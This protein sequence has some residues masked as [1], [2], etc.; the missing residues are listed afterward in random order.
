[1][2]IFHDVDGCLNTPDGSPIGFSKT[3]LSEN[4]IKA[5]SDL[6]QLIDDSAVKHFVLNTGRN[7]DAT[8][9]L[10]PANSVNA[11]KNLC[12]EKGHLS[13]Y[14]YIATTSE[15]IETER[16][17]ITAVHFHFLHG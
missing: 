11:V 2:I 14:D 7:W 3:A 13:Q 1:M 9:Y 5:L 8:E 17:Y 4:L 6:G 12:R 16:P 15:W 10:C